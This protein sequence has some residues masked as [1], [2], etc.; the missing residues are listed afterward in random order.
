MKIKNNKRLLLVSSVVVLLL[1]IGGIGWAVTTAVEPSSKVVKLYGGYRFD[2]NEQRAAENAIANADL[3]GH[4][5]DGDQLQV[6]TN[7]RSAYIAALARNNVLDEINPARLGMEEK[8]NPWQNDR[9]MASKMMR[10]KELDSA[11]A[12]KMLPGIANAQ[13][14][15]NTRPVWER[16]VWAR[17]QITSVGVSVEANDNLPIS[18]ETLVA[19][20]RIIKPVFGITDSKEIRIVDVK[21]VRTYDG[22]G[23]EIDTHNRVIAAQ[24]P[25]FSFFVTNI[26]AEKE[27]DCVT[28]LKAIPG[29][30]DA[31]V[32][33]RECYPNAWEQ[34]PRLSVC[35][36]IELDENTPFPA[37]TRDVIGRFVAL[38]FD[39]TDRQDI[40]IID[41]KHNRVYDGSGEEIDELDNDDSNAIASYVMP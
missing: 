23:E 8:I 35:I 28:A 2:Q 9:V 27:K 6:P 7:K 14:I 11:N 5:W 13:V 26:I 40:R 16:N 37:D 20:G 18:A 29:V 3:I 36:R 31:T 22:A 1:V 33:T 21:C 24:E 19:I 30:V 12:I 10:A 17:T 38:I 25:Q 41:A 15:T 39:I 34:T 32:F 4:Y